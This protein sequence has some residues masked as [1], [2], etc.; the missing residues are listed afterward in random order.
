MDHGAA[1][2][3]GDDTAGQGKQGLIRDLHHHALDA[4]R[5][6]DLQADDPAGI[7]PEG[8]VRGGIEGGLPR[9]HLGRGTEGQLPAPEIGR[10]EIEPRY[11]VGAVR[12]DAAHGVPLPGGEG[13]HQLPHLPRSRGMYRSDRGRRDKSPVGEE[14]N[15]RVHVRDPVAQG[16]V[17]VLLAKGEG[18]DAGG[19]LPDP[20]PQPVLARGPLPGGAQGKGQ[21]SLLPPDGQGHLLLV[22]QQIHEAHG[23]P[24][25]L[26][27][28]R[29]DGVAL[30]EPGGVGGRQGPLRRVH[31]GEAHHLDPLRIEDDAH[32]PSPQAHGGQG[33]DL[34]HG[35]QR[36]HAKEGIGPLHTA[37]AGVATAPDGPGLGADE[38]ARRRLLPRRHALG[39]SPEGPHGR[40]KVPQKQQ[41][42]EPRR[43]D[44]S[45][46]SFHGD[47]M[48]RGPFFM[49][50]YPLLT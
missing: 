1:G 25:G 23:T 49:P 32:G 15:A 4:R 44:L 33:G 48:P 29:Q 18:A 35:A 19:A 2:H 26:S 13:A 38:P 24:D 22:L 31:G 10:A 50:L 17:P 40:G 46:P 8:P 41:G 34:L 45:D 42:A 37:Q 28:H 6:L 12:V 3:A 39:Q 43:Y 11:A 21:D 30:F 5:A 20:G 14:G 16:A 47:R 27:V 36:H 7:A 9:L